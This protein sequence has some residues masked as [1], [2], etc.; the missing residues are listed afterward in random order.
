MIVQTLQEDATTVL[1]GENLN[2]DS[3][4]VNGSFSVKKAQSGTLYYTA[5]VV[6]GF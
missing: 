5:H 4:Q 3:D 2:S 6:G 1:V